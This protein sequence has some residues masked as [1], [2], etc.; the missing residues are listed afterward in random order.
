MGVLNEKM[1][2]MLKEPSLLFIHF[3]FKTHMLRCEKVYKPFK[4]RL[5]KFHSCIL[6][7][8]FFFR[9]SFFNF[10]KMDIFNVQN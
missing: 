1:C 2:K 5:K 3:S 6:N 9:E 10:S 4:K 7:I 8:L